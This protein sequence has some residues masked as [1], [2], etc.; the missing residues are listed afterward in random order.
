MTRN[1]R[2]NINQRT[3]NRHL[4]RRMKAGLAAVRTTP[5]K[6]ALAAVYLLGAMLVWLFR[7][8]LFAL[9]TYGMFSPVLEAVINLLLPLYA[10][11][12]LLALL[13]LLGTPWGGR[14]A[15]E[16]LQ[17]VGLVNHAG[18][19]P[20]LLSKRPDTDNPRLTVWEFDP[21]G[22]PLNEWEDKQA[23][24][25]TALDITIAKIAWAE[26]R[27]II[28]VH[29]VPAASELPSLLRWEDKYLSPESFVLVL[30]DFGI[31][32]NS[33]REKYNLDWLEDRPWTT[34]FLD[35]NHENYDTL[36]NLPVSEW[37]GGKVHSLRP[38]VI[39][40]MR[41]QL[42]TINGQ[43]LF[44]FGGARSH[45][46]R[47]GILEPG[48]PRIKEWRNSTVRRLYRVNHVS[49]WAREMPSDEE[50]EK[51]LENLQKAGNR[52]SI[53]ATHCPYT[54]LL[55]KIDG[56]SGLYEADKL[57]DYLQKIHDTIDYGVWLCGHMH[58]NRKF[59]ADKIVC[60]YEQIA[61]LI[62]K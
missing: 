30:G 61:P 31:W 13:V 24:I 11:G 26:G 27:K 60:L 46:I 32:D 40:L 25:E 36:D 45:D 38:S 44:T 52:V 16:G 18:E 19:A 58:I 50:M 12:G 22:I 54:T 55:E 49:W 34:L 8:R 29:A 20:V 15:R 43:S 33:R 4:L 53:I 48:D 23:R 3:E 57:S 14:T 47:D 7:G 56:G 17:K 42:Y 21:C 39:H 62:K 1:D 2:D 9:D 37:N 35:G 41:G 6:G 10:V 51:G 59:V 28:R 5:Y